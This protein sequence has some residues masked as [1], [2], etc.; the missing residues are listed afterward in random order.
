MNLV[1]IWVLEG[2]GTTAMMTL[3]EFSQHILKRQ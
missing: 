1:G 2:I 3:L